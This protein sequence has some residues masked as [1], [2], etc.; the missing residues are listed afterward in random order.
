MEPTFFL[1]TSRG[2]TATKWI[3]RVL[4]EHPA[5]YC[6]HSAGTEVF[7]RDYTAAE[8]EAIVEDKWLVRDHAPVVEFLE[9]LTT[10][11]DAT[12]F[13]NVH[14]YSLTSL[15]L[16][17]DRFPFGGKVRIANMVR[18]PVS[19]VESGTAQ[20]MTMSQSVHYVRLQLL[21]H[22]IA[23]RAMYRR[24]AAEAD[25]LAWETLSFFMMCFRL[26]EWAGEARDRAVRHFRMEDITT[27]PRAFAGLVEHL[28]GIDISG[29]AAYLERSLG[30]GKIHR[31]ARS[32]ETGT[33]A[34]WAGW[35]PWQRR[36]FSFWSERAALAEAF[37]RF[38]Y[39][40]PEHG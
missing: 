19:W 29:D 6:N 16:N 20:M 18:H 22:F 32:A 5:I 25:L 31:H 35:Q 23:H 1:V 26:V 4:S 11:K 38:E 13:G 9:S 10:R 21:K 7:D 34:L 28:S 39:L 15:R 30:H 37:A 2:Y 24:V 14:R 36:V 17:F 33:G 27:D 40:L 8:L 12:A 3:A